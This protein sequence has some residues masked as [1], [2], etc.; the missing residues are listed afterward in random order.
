MLGAGD[1]RQGVAHVQFA[2]QVGVEL[3][4]GDLELGRRRPV[5]DVEGLHGVA[6]A[7]AEAFHRAMRHVEQR[8][9]VGVVAVGQ[10]QAVAR[11][12]A[13]EMAEGGLDRVQVRRRCPRGRTPGC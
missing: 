10:Q 9:Q 5:A 1:D 11:D 6:L 3:E 12:E 7:Q 4:A 8:G 2:H 13:D